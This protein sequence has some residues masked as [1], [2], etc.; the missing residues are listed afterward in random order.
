MDSGE[1]RVLGYYS[2]GGQGSA[3]VQNLY[4]A[5]TCKRPVRRFIMQAGI[6][7]HRVA[8]VLDHRAGKPAFRV[9]M[10]IDSGWI[11]GQKGLKG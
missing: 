4:N 8:D 9:Y 2:L 3:W 10:P 7:A 6:T 5:L 1:H 11:P